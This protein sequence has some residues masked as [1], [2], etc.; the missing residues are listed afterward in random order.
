[1]Q[2]AWRTDGTAVA[3]TRSR[4]ATIELTTTVRRM[5][6]PAKLL[7]KLAVDEHAVSMA[8]YALLIAFLTLGTI[9]VF[10]SLTDAINTFFRS[11][12]SDLS[13]M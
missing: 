4:Y 13:A 6:Y 10:N 5:R 7:M 3:S 12:A 8:E 11:T 2:S 1:M 9:T